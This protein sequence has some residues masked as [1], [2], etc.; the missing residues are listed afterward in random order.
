MACNRQGT[1]A[2]RDVFLFGG[3]YNAVAPFS[4]GTVSVPATA[5]S[6][7]VVWAPLL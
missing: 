7:Y 1:G 6:G 3:A 2:A 5:N 4:F